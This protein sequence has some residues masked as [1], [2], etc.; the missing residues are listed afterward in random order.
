MDPARF[1]LLCTQRDEQKKQ[2]QKMKNRQQK[3]REFLKSLLFHLN[4]SV[5]W[6]RE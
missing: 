6:K 1:M 4:R 5:K 2:K 3:Q